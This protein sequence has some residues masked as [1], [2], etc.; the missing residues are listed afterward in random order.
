MKAN[1]LA[2]RLVLV[3]PNVHSLFRGFTMF[4]AMT[5]LI[6]ELVATI[7]KKCVIMTVNMM[8]QLVMA[9]TMVIMIS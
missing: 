9:M 6:T 5:K 3:Y 7:N 2:L 4:T 1:L 8:M